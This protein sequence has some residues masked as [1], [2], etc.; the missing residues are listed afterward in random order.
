MLTLI[1]ILGSLPTNGYPVDVVLNP[2]KPNEVRFD[3]TAIDTPE[4]TDILIQLPYAPASGTP[5]LIVIYRPDHPQTIRG[6][7]GSP[8]SD[9]TIPIIPDPAPV[10]PNDP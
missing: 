10:D 7:I 6:T 1:L 2:G 5:I 3:G 8:S 9:G 4:G